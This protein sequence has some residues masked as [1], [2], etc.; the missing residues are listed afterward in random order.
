MRNREL[1]NRKIEKIEGNCKQ[2]LFIV[3]RGESIDT[4]KN[5]IAQTEEILAEIKNLVA[6]EPM[7]SDEIKYKL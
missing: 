1:L 6:M 7:G 3:S 4:Y 2:L 5:I